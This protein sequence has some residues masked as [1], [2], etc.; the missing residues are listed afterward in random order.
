MSCILEIIFNA[1]C[2]ECL[3][4]NDDANVKHWKTMSKSVFAW[5]KVIL[6]GMMKCN[7]FLKGCVQ[8]KPFEKGKTL[9]RSKYTG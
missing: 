1:V 3:T 6:I 4:D 5:V 7:W 2:F 8:L 9:E